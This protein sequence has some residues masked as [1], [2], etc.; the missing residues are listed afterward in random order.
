[1][2]VRQF[3]GWANVRA[4]QFH[5]CDNSEI[6]TKTETE[7]GQASIYVND[8]K[9]SKKSSKQYSHK[10]K[11]KK[12][13]KCNTRHGKRAYPK[14]AELN[15]PTAPRCDVGCQS[16]KVDVRNELCSIRLMSFD[17]IEVVTRM[18]QI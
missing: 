15:V 1:M 5:A 4:K 14:T 9:H 8:S 17:N 3:A 2:W 13:Q 6:A 10:R 7:L 18:P 16:Y 11:H 12:R